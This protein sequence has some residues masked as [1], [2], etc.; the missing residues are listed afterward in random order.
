MSGIRSKAPKILQSKSN[1]HRNDFFRGNIIYTFL[2][3]LDRKLSYDVG[4]S[5]RLGRL[6]P[7]SSDGLEDLSCDF[8]RC[9]SSLHPLHHEYPMRNRPTAKGKWQNATNCSL[10]DSFC[11]SYLCFWLRSHE[12]LHKSQVR[13]SRSSAGIK[14]SCLNL[15]HLTPVRKRFGNTPVRLSVANQ[16]F[17]LLG[18]SEQVLSLFKASRDLTT[19]PNVLRILEVGFGTPVRFKHLFTRDTTG[20]YH[21]PFEGSKF[22]EPRK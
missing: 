13:K 9:P 14:S 8:L 20:L 16:N 18:G 12:L 2:L 22:L 21:V 5:S 17:R 3:F 6:V 10:H 11:R 15:I 7:W 4:L 1:R 19:I